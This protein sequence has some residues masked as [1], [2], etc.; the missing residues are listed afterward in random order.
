MLIFDNHDSH[1]I[2]QFVTYAYE[3]NIVLI[4]LSLYF[5]YRFQPLDVAVFDLLTKYYFDIVKTKN[6]YERKNVSKRE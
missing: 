6:R 4:Y 3:Y 5:I 2:I 1:E